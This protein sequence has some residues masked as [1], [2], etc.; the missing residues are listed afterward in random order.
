ML[1]S[2]LWNVLALNLL[3]FGAPEAHPDHSLASTYNV[4][5]WH[6]PGQAKVMVYVPPGAVQR[7]PM[8]ILSVQVG[9]ALCLY[10]RIKPIFYYVPSKA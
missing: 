5:M 3:P 2:T 6:L 8:V 7:G 4:G 9:L 1:C 10:W